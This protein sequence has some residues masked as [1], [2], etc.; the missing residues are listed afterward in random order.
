MEKALN[1]QCLLPLSLKNC[2]HYL[3]TPKSMILKMETEK[4]LI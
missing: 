1:L 2:D 3:R 4:G